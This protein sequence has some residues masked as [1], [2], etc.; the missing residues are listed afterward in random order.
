[1][2]DAIFETSKREEDQSL[3]FWRRH[4]SIGRPVDKHTRG[5]DGISKLLWYR[6]RKDQA[7]RELGKNHGKKKEETPRGCCPGI[8]SHNKLLRN[9]ETSGADQK[10]AVTTTPSPVKTTKS[11]LLSCAPVL[12]RNLQPQRPHHLLRTTK[13][14]WLSC[15]RYYPGICSHNDLL[16]RKTPWVLSKNIAA[17]DP[18]SCPSRLHACSSKRDLFFKDCGGN[19]KL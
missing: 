2:V 19:C 11:R 16:R 3:W 9:E 6:R 8:Y 4:L 12:S 10:F 7:V 5:L 1:M 13:S 15:F 17:N 18:S 14:R